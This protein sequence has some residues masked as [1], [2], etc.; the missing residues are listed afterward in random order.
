MKG[1]IS[2]VSPWSWASLPWE[3][4]A[5]LEEEK[6]RKTDRKTVSSFGA[7]Y[8]IMHSLFCL[9]FKYARHRAVITVFL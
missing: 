5:L 7:W 3:W 1:R 6:H 2:M 4:K 9:K 8:L